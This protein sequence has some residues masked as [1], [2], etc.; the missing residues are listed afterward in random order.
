MPEAYESVLVPDD[1][2]GD[3]RL[4]KCWRKFS[5]FIGPGYM[6][7][8]GYMDPGNWATDIAGGALFK[9][10]LLFV[11]LFPSVMAMFLQVGN[12]PSFIVRTHTPP[13]AFFFLSLS[14]TIIITIG[15]H[16]GA[17]SETWHRS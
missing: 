10:S 16:T 11:V 1:H 2:E 9:Y 3:S 15:T 7:A 5:A 17:N 4:R 8:V 13:P 12:C 14:D 6:V